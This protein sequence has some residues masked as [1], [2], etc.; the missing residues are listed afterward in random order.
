MTNIFAEYSN[1]KAAFNAQQLAMIDLLENGVTAA[2][3]EVIQGALDDD[4]ITLSKVSYLVRYYL[5]DVTYDPDSNTL[6]VT[7]DGQTHTISIPTL[8]R[9]TKVEE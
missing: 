7:A 9:V 5:E 8:L 2:L 6:I 3:E 1:A 4:V